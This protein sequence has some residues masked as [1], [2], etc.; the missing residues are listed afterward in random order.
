MLRP[1]ALAA[2]LFALPSCVSPN[3]RELPPAPVHWSTPSD[4]SA[5]TTAWLPTLK[6]PALT[7]L[8]EEALA[9]NPSLAA[10]AARLKAARARANIAGADLLPEFDLTSRSSRAQ[11]LLGA[12]QSSV[13]SNNFDLSLGL[14]WELDLWGRLRQERAAALAETAAAASDLHAARLSLAANVAKAA[15]NVLEATSQIRLAEEN[16][17]RLRLSLDVLEGQLDRGIA[18][19]RLPLDISLARSDLATAKANVEATRRDADAARRTLET[20]VGRY[21]EGR[22]R[23]LERFPENLAAVPTG[24]PSQLLLRRPDIIA[25]E[26][27]AAAA[28]ARHTAAGRAL[29]PAAR[30]TGSAGRGST[31]LRDLL[32]PTA[33]IWNIAAGLTQPV[34]RGGALRANVALTAAQAEEIVE[35]YRDSALTAFQ[36]VET[37]LAAGRLLDQQH[38]LTLTAVQEATNAVDFA[39]R[40][41]DRGLADTLTVLESQRRLAS[42]RQAL[43]ALTNLRLQNRIDLHLAL[44][45][46]F[47]K[48]PDSNS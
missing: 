30:I 35:N 9:Q 43:L 3:L 39:T 28:L 18:T 21:P 24:L 14:S 46:D 7:R 42:A 48:F 32:D 11:R 2:L 19:E 5:A 29:L 45:G 40:S 33:L 36:E 26:R 47:Q 16:A 31:E 44:G 22:I 12:Q 20:L 34:V 23:A 27:R 1:L 6:S 15:L 17:T 8:V 37:A 13:R 41:Y 10:T 25:A 38:R 4:A